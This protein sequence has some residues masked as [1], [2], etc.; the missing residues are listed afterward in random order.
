MFFE[1]AYSPINHISNSFDLPISNFRNIFHQ[2]ISIKRNTSK[3]IVLC[4]LNLIFIC[5]IILNKLMS[6]GLAN[7]CC[8]LFEL[9]ETSSFFQKFS[10]DL[11]F[12]LCSRFFRLA[13][14]TSGSGVCVGCSGGEVSSTSTEGSCITSGGIEWSCSE[15]NGGGS[16]CC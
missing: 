13:S 3:N 1:T 5:S 14:C 7:R 6:G 12:R 15:T 8:S 2:K 16:S 4:L 11:E 10:E 9:Q